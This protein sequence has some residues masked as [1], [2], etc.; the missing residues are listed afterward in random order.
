MI[1]GVK[2]F[3]YN[4]SHME[5]A[6]KFY[7]EALGMKL[8]KEGEVWSTL[9]CCGVEVGLHWTRGEPVKKVSADIHGAQAGGTLTLRSSDVSADRSLLEQRGA[10]IVGEQDEAWGHLLVF[11]DPDGNVLKLMHPKH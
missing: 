7:T 6:I 5:R 3:N 10:K 9:E 4:V 11:E 1:D 8:L 2:D